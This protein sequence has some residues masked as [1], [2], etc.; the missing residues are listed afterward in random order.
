MRAADKK[1]PRVVEALAAAKGKRVIAKRRTPSGLPFFGILP[2]SFRL[3]PT[4]AR[5]FVHQPLVWL[6]GVSCI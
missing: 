5:F 4:Q 6:L 2:S 3:S 1:E